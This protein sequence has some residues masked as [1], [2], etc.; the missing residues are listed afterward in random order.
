MKTIQN[1]KDFAQSIDT[2][3]MVE[4]SA[5][6]REAQKALLCGPDAPMTESKTGYHSVSKYGNI[7][8]VWTESVR[9]VPD[10]MPPPTIPCVRRRKPSN[11]PRC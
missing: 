10:S 8:I 6:L 7:K 1:F 2:I 5:T 9:T 4:A 3:Y 11:V